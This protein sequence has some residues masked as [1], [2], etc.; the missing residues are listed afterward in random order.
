MNVFTKIENGKRVLNIDETEDFSIDECIFNVLKEYN[1]TWTKNLPAFKNPE[2]SEWQ[3]TQ[4]IKLLVA[5]HPRSVENISLSI[6]GEIF[7]Y[8][9][10]KSIWFLNESKE[11]GSDSD[12]IEHMMETVRSN[13]GKK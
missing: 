8:T 13:W 11:I 7:N 5:H 1:F 4:D 6:K 12:M 3:L 9:R 2:M 10:Y